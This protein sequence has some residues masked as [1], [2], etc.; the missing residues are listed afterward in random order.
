MGANRTYIIIIQEG[1]RLNNECVLHVGGGVD[2]IALYI[3]HYA[4]VHLTFFKKENKSNAFTDF[5]KYIFMEV[6]L[7]VE[8]EEV[9]IVLIKY[10]MKLLPSVT[11]STFKI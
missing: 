5:N 9:H 10:N 2:H 6:V 7:H 8:L 1:D 4:H 3:L 11:F